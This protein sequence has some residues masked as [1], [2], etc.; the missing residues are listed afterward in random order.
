MTCATH[1]NASKGH[2]IHQKHHHAKYAVA[3]SPL[4]FLLVS[5]IICARSPEDD[6]ASFILDIIS[7][8]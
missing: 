5:V 2:S 7:V 4:F 1:S 8:M 3:L 6:F